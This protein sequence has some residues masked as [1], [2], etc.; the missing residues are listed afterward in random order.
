VAAQS[1]GAAGAASSPAVTAEVIAR[2]N[3]FR[4]QQRLVSVQPEPHLTAAAGEFA[5]YFAAHRVLEHEADGRDP[6][7]R[8][9]AHGYSYCVI[10]ENIAFEQRPGGFATEELASRLVTNWQNSPPHR[11][12]MQDPRVTQ[13]GVG[14]AP[15]PGGYWYAVQLFGL[16]DSARIAFRV[17]NDGTR[18][19]AYTVAGERFDLPPGV[20]RTHR[21]CPPAQLQVTGTTAPVQVSGGALY[22]V[23]NDGSGWHLD[24]H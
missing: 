7:Q 13:T 3:A 6:A 15:A 11:H 21:L 9:Q 5:G 10:A 1:A 17:I 4:E 24:T 8:A 12:N 16:P 22:H 18:A 2:V 23:R 14:I 19:A 20:T